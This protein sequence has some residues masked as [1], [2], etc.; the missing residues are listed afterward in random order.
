MSSRSVGAASAF[1]EPEEM[2][3]LT[4]ETTCSRSGQLPLMDSKFFASTSDTNKA[5]ARLSR[6]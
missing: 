6:N 5:R 2:K 4:L 3:S 1:G